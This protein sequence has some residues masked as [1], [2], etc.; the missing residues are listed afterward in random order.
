MQIVEMKESNKKEVIALLKESLGET[1]AEKTIDYWNWKHE[2]NPFGK[3][4]VLLAT[5]EDQIIGVRAFMKW[6]WQKEAK[7]IHAVRAVDTATL[8]CHQGKGVFKKLTLE[9]V[10]QC[11]KEGDAFVFN[12][13]NTT[14]K[15]GYLKMGWSEAGRLPVYFGVGSLFP[16][17]YSEK[18]VNELL[19]KFSSQEQVQKLPA[20]WMVASTNKFWHT[21][22]NAAYLKWRY[23]HCPVV[24]Y[25]AIIE[26]NKFGVIFRLKKLNAF[27]ELR[28][29]E[30]WAAP[31]TDSYSSAK[32]AV[33]KICKSVRPFIV[34]CAPSPLF[35]K[36]VKSSLGLVSAFKKG[37]ETTIRTLYKNDLSDF[38]K[39]KNWQPSL[40][41]MELF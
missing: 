39:L 41:S 21:A 9:A 19:S 25:G 5:E 10:Q 20:D 12:T 35:S 32:E 23:V 6:Q 36:D 26:P 28:I 30:I 37:P 2:Q 31:Q 40:G 27:I 3:S 33:T 18:M 11:T 4:K 14:S 13:P 15:Q 17:L 1:S 24:K 22:I 7:I 34:S 29:C 8:P 38:H 16:R